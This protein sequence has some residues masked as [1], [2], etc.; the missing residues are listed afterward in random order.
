[1]HE[2]TKIPDVIAR[3]FHCRSSKNQ[4]NTSKLICGFMDAIERK[5]PDKT[6]LLER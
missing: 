3:I 1:M 5:I 4:I 6:H 2:R